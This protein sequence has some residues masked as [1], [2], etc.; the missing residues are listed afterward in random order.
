MNDSDKFA[1]HHWIRPTSWTIALLLIALFSILTGC[2]NQPKQVVFE[3]AEDM[4]GLIILVDNEQSPITFE[5]RTNSY[6]LSIDSSGIIE[7]RDLIKL[8]GHII[9]TGVMKN[10]VFS[11]GFLFYSQPKYESFFKDD[12]SF[13]GSIGGDPNEEKAIWKYM[14]VFFINGV[15]IHAFF[16]GTLEEAKEALNEMRDE[17]L[18]AA[19]KIVPGV[20]ISPEEFER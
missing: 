10:E 17:S 15:L 4:S 13:D 18:A 1:I 2:K 11:S 3:I 14:P 19:R 20:A 7:V 16:F 8:D 6:H 5:K 12:L 9:L